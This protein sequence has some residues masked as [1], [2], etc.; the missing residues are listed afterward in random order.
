M[1]AALLVPFLA[2]L[3]GV[4]RLTVVP[5]DAVAALPVEA[6]AEPGDALPPVRYAPSLAVLRQTRDASGPS[7]PITGGRPV[8]IAA[9]GDPVALLAIR[10]SY[11]DSS[12]AV[13]VVAGPSALFADDA[14]AAV[15]HFGAAAILDPAS[16][17]SG[18]PELIGGPAGSAGGDRLASGELLGLDLDGAVVV[19]AI[20]HRPLPAVADPASWRDLARDALA[21]GAGAV[22]VSL[23]DPP[24]DSGPVLAA[25]LHAGLAAGLTPAEALDRARR[26]VGRRAPLR[27]PRPLGRLRRSTTPGQNRDDRPDRCRTD[28]T[29]RSAELPAD[30]AHARVP[31]ARGPRM[32][33]TGWPPRALPFAFHDRIRSS[34]T[35]SIH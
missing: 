30:P 11:A 8:R 3:G 31:S 16:S 25:A 2:D 33:S 26:S 22:V 17:L 12:R 19:L 20:R 18:D 21:A 5:D 13:E 15:L 9:A 6:I 14:K 10:S 24:A 35:S 27:R 29:E 1:R 4:D 32:R 23:W 7:R 28:P 34:R